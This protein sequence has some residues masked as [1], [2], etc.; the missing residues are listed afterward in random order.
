MALDDIVVCDTAFAK[1][2]FGSMVPSGIE[3]GGR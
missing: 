3:I 1:E 2:S